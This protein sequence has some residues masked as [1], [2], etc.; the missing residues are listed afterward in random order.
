[1]QIQETKLADSY[2]YVFGFG[3]AMAT[4]DVLVLDSKYYQNLFYGKIIAEY[5]TV[6]QRWIVNFKEFLYSNI[7]LIPSILL[8]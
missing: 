5:P 8:G 2:P 6:L 1:M 4:V 7:P 3:K